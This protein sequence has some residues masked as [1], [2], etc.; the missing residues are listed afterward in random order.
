MR[1]ECG[2]HR[3]DNTSLTASTAMGKGSSANDGTCLKGGERRK[4]GSDSRERAAAGE[5]QFI[6]GGK[7][8]HLRKTALIDSTENHGEVIENEEQ[9]R[10]DLILQERKKKKLKQAG[11]Y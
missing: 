7:R 2:S 8:E 9:K 5:A 6:P 4:E 3:T 1:V 11:C 10:E